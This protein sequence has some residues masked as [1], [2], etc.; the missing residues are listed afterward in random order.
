[1]ALQDEFGLFAEYYQPVDYAQKYY[2]FVNGKAKGQSWLGG[3]SLL[4][5]FVLNGYDPFSWGACGGRKFVE[6][7]I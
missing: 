1:M 7:A 2:F 4:N 3:N 6:S 5:A